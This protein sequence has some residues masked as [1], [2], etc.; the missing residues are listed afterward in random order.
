ML[1][2]LSLQSS[3][4]AEQKT[5]LIFFIGGCTYAEISA[6]RFLSQSEDS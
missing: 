6:F 4:N 2:S 3:Q 5:T 1:S